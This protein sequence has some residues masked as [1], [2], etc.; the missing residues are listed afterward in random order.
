MNLAAFYY[1]YLD[2][3]VESLIN[4]GFTTVPQNA[5][6]AQI[7]GLDFD[8]TLK[9]NEAFQTKLNTTYL[10]RAEYKS[11]PNAIVYVPP[12]TPFGFTADYHYDASGTRM[13]AAPLWSGT[14]STTYTKPLPAGVFEATPSLYYTSA[15]RWVY[16]GA[17]QTG[18]YN[19]LNARLS[20]TPTSSRFRYSVYGKNL[21]NRA[22]FNGVTPGPGT[23]V[24]FYGQPREVGATVDFSF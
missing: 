12:L 7:Y 16:T 14:V 11:F 9:W 5:A 10:P 13:L 15:Y 20:F 3:Q 22:Y 1:N 21:A 6:K 19:L 24:S 17:V 2:L 4:H 18:S 23:A 8:G